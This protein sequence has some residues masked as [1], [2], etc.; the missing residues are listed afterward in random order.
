MNN[1]PI[2]EELARV[3]RAEST[4]DS[5]LSDPR[6][7]LLAAGTISPEDKAALAALAESSPDAAL[8]WQAFQP[9]G[10]AFEEGVAKAIRTQQKEEQWQARAASRPSF[11]RR[12]SWAFG[13][14]GAS[15]MVA[16]ALLLAP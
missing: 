10:P 15:G 14:L 2:L 5:V 3:A 4:D 11:F 12:L 13:G 1:D 9:L 8:A 16:A 7:E 6:W